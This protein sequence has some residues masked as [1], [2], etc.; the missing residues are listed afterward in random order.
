MTISD[1]F[2]DIKNSRTNFSTVEKM[3]F[4]KPNISVID[5]NNV[6]KTKLAKKNGTI[7]I[8][9]ILLMEADERPWAANNERAIRS[10]IKVTRKGKEL[11]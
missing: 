8:L 9:S 10:S 11:L 1:L 6:K 2:T 4:L 7:L 5:P 3:A